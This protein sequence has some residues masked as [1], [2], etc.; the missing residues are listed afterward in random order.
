M[1][2]KS[3]ISRSTARTRMPMCLCVMVNS[4]PGEYVRKIIFKQSQ[5]NFSFLCQWYKVLF[6]KDYIPPG[7]LPPH[8]NGILCPFVFFSLFTST[9]IHFSELTSSD[10][11]TCND[12]TSCKNQCPKN[13]AVC[14][15]RCPSLC[16][17]G[18]CPSPK[19]CSK[20]TA[21]RCPC[22]RKKKVSLFLT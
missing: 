3:C 10:E 9:F 7:H 22:R 18:S 8:F 11:Q 1:S 12:L 19:T 2:Q 17:A 15:H 13:L 4:E 20:K 14:G 16:H 6:T 5:W 21:V